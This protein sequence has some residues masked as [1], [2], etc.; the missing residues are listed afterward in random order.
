MDSAA[1]AALLRGWELAESVGWLGR[2]ATA[3]KVVLV[4]GKRGRAVP[5]T[6]I[7]LRPRETAW[8]KGEKRARM[9]ERVALGPL[10][11]TQ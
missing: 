8:G 6:R 9:R 3:H 7:L 1:A 10:Q 4:G 2:E 5:H 11:G